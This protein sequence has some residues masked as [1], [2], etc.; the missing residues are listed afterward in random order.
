MGCETEV[1]SLTQGHPEGKGLT[2]SGQMLWPILWPQKKGLEQSQG[3]WGRL[4]P[5]RRDR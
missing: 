1:N 3:G 5:S 2:L 4:G